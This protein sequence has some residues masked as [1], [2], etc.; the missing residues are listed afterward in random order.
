MR[1]NSFWSMVGIFSIESSLIKPLPCID[2]VHSDS[3]SINH[4]F[5][6]V[7]FS[8]QP[9][10]FSADMTLKGNTTSRIESTRCNSVFSLTIKLTGEQKRSFCESSERSERQLSALLYAHLETQWVSDCSSPE[11]SCHV[12]FTWYLRGLLI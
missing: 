11:E 9:Q 1:T 5:A 4:R 2:I 6:G 10:R 3:L 12:S 8:S 7:G